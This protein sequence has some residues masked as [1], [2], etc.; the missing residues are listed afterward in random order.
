M[1]GDTGC[2]PGAPKLRAIFHNRMRRG[3][4]SLATLSKSRVQRHTY[5]IAQLLIGLCSVAL[6]VLLFA[7]SPAAATCAD[8][9]MLAHSTVSITRYFAD[10]DRKADTDL[11]GIR[12]TAWFLSP[13]SMVTAEHVATAMELSDQNWKQVEILEGESKQTIDARILR[14][15]GS[16]S[17]KLT[18]LEL[19]TA[20]SGAHGLTIR[21]EPLAPE[22]P[23]LS[24]AYPGSRLRSVGGRFIKYG[25]SDKLAGTALLEL[26]DRDDRLVLD[27]GASGAPVLD[28]EGRV[29]AVVSNIFTQTLQFPSRAIRISTAWGSPNVAS[30]PIQV[31][32]DY[33]QAQ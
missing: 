19:R 17:E 16:H 7:V 14:V 5:R 27:H 31:L 30:V 26:Y 24:I 23:V 11:L 20:F 28:C 25:D 2:G 13:T 18:V 6:G 10:D 8:A 9:S 12:G 4:P 33:S 22:E 29:V 15:A 1:S 21:M 3:A 32:Q